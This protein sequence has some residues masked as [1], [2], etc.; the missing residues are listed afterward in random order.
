VFEEAV[1]VARRL[2]DPYLI[3]GTAGD[4]G[5]FEY[6][7]GNYGRAVE[8]TTEALA[9][10]K[11]RGDPN[12]IA[13][14]GVSLLALFVAGGNVIE[15]RELSADVVADVLK[16][17]A[18]ARLAECAELLAG[19]HSK[20]G[21]LTGAA[22]LLGAAQALRER[23]GMTLYSEHAAL[24]DEALQACR[25]ALPVDVFER[26]FEDGMNMTVEA[27]LAGLGYP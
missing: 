9:S 26:C 14:N 22:T 27:A 15:A 24:H 11:E 25:T 19:L 4:L 3:S 7:A 8:L 1:E 23:V 5:M 6:L 21:E 18:P 13:V 10:A 20:T 17:G 2:R 12:G 16:V